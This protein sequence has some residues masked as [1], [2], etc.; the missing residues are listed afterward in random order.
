V[1]GC[2]SESRMGGV[3]VYEVPAGW[4]R[5]DRVG[6]SSRLDGSVRPAAPPATTLLAAATGEEALPTAMTGDSGGS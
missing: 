5:A 6:F 2:D 1:A 3:G 4:A